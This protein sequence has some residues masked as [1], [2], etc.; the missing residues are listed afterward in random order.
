MPDAPRTTWIREAS[1]VVAGVCIAMFAQLVI[2][3]IITIDDRQEINERQF[4]IMQQKFERLLEECR[5]D[6]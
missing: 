3:W 1:L 5:R 6:E 4:A 2:G